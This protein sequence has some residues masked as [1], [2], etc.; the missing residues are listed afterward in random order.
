VRFM[1]PVVL[2]TLAVLGTS[3]R[4]ADSKPTGI[5]S[6]LTYNT[7]GGDLSGV[8]VLILPGIG[9]GFRAFVQIAEGGAPFAALVPVTITGDS[10]AFWVRDYAAIPG[11][12]FSGTLDAGGITGRWY[13]GSKQ[14]DSFGGS[15]VERL[16]RG[17]SYWQ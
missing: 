10:V 13:D 15:S 6:D 16:K 8:E 2:L 1:L 5:F 11:L 14:I 4:A 17:K 3:A 12:R 9:S 7:V